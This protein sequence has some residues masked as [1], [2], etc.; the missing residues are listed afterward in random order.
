MNWG[1]SFGTPLSQR[2]IKSDAPWNS[3][4]EWTLRHWHR[5]S[6]IQCCHQQPCIDKVIPIYFKGGPES[7]PPQSRMSHIFISDKARKSKPSKDELAQI[8]RRH[9]SLSGKRSPKA[10]EDKGATSGSGSLPYIA[11]LVDLGQP[12][13]FSVTFPERE[14]GD[15]C[16]RIYAAGVDAAI[17]PFLTKY[18][19]LMKTLEDLVHLQQLPETETPIREYLDAQVSFGDTAFPENMVWERGRTVP[20]V[21]RDLVDG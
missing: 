3:L 4:Y 19:A 13:S 6:G 21:R 16:L 9:E 8:T 10:D 18:P 12:S 20:N 5:T 17:Y 7:A 14:V 1:Q 15:R 2:D 11:I